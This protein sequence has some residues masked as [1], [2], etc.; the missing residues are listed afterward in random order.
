MTET[1]V[2]RGRVLNGDPDG[3]I[4]DGIV[5]FADGRVTWVGA[6]SDYPRDAPQPTDDVIMPGLIDLHCHGGGGFDFPTADA[7]GARTAAAHH[8]R[9]GTTGLMGSLV[10]AQPDVLARQATMLADLVEDNTLLGVH[11]EGPFLNSAR[12]GAQDPAAITDGDPELFNNLCETARGTVRAMTVAPETA[13]FPE[14]LAAMRTADV[15]PSLGHTDANA[16]ITIDAIG[17]AT[18]D[19]GAVTATH[20]FNGMPPLHH[21]SPGPVGA[22]LAAAGRGDI[23]VELIAD[24][25]H[26]AP[27]TVDLVFA[28]VGPEQIALVSD[29]MAAAGM[30]D[31]DYQLGPLAVRVRDGV[32]R[33]ATDDGSPGAIAGGT[34]TL[35]EVVRWTVNEAKVPLAQAVSS[36]T[37]TPA[38]VLGLADERGHIAVGSRADLLVTDHSL[39]PRR[40]LSAGK[41]T[42]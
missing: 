1:E 32:A 9:N 4:A 19:G 5:E 7:E 24:G 23:V 28:T 8:R 13:R 2:M 31:G 6:A 20:L 41:E 36:A 21:R 42:R 22:C 35:L 40:V 25:V 37:A 30:R 34:S 15:L 12:C 26:L 18:S 10:S 17:A 39:R 3:D 27:E 14:L 33:L 38:R 29:A 11:L 16:A